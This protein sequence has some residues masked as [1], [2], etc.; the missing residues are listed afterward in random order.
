MKKIISIILIILLVTILVLI[1][2]NYKEPSQSNVESPIK[3][4]T[5][6]N[7]EEAKSPLT[8]E[9]EA[10]GPWFFEATFPVKIYDANNNLLGTGIAQAKDNWMQ[11]DFVPFEAKVSFDNPGMGDG[12][13]VLE[14]ANPSGLAKNA[15]ELRINIKFKNQERNISLYYYNTSLDNGMCSKEGLI[16][17]ERQIPI[18]MTPIQDT[19]NL[20]L[21]GELTQEERER[22]ITT[23]FPLEGV[24]LKG[25]SLKNGVLTLNFNDPNHKTSGGSCRAGILWFQISETA[26]QFPQ[27]EIVKFMPEELFQ[28]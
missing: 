23:E 13:I 12:V 3:V 25:A 26:K 9:G 8:I 18:T 14:K 27:V 10:R 24:E 19:I 2:L 1:G 17:V 20:L 28:P 4:Y 22:G 5:P 6:V 11:S 15:E 7:G 16:K 21:K